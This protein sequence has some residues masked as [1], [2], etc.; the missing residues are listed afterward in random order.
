MCP[1]SICVPDFNGGRVT[2]AGNL[3]IGRCFI[4]KEEVGDSWVFTSWVKLQ[5]LV[6]I[7]SVANLHDP[8]GQFVILNRINDAVIPL[9]NTIE[10]LSR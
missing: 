1:Q 8:D 10:L 7:F 4:L 3:Q 5:P 6:N 9:S 2:L